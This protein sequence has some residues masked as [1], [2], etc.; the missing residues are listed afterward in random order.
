MPP[1]VRNTRMLAAAALLVALAGCVVGPDFRP[2][3][4]P[5]TSV[6][7][8]GLLSDVT[9]SA[10][11]PGG[12]AQKFVPGNDIPA[13]WWSLF[14][15]PELDQVIR[16]ALAN[17]PNLA[18]AQATLRVSLENYRALTGSVLYPSVDAS[19]SATH[20]KISGASNGQS[21]SHFSPFTLYNASVNVSYNLDLFGGVRRELEALQA[22]VDSQR[23]QLH[24]AYL[25]ITANIVTAAVHEALVRAQIRTTQEILS[26]QEKQLEVVR[27][28]FQLGAVSR[29]DVLAQQAQVAQTRATL[30][31]LEQELFRTRHLLAVLAGL[32]PSEADRLPQFELSSLHLPQELP[33]SLP[34][35]LVRR[36]PDIRASESL[37][38]AASAQV[39]VATAN[40][41]PRIRLTATFGSEANTG[42]D[43]FS[44]GTGV[45]SIGAGIFQPIF[46]GGALRSQKRAAVAAYEQASA[47]YRATVLQAFQNVA[48]VLRALETDARTLAAQAESEAASVEALDVA[49]K[50][51]D[52]GSVSF[53]TLL[54]AQRQAQQAQIGLVQAQAVRYADSA[55]L[56]QAL[57]GGWW[58]DPGPARSE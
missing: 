15:S 58:N 10:Q 20:D 21:A 51:F 17:N 25:T 30:P 57:G 45:W 48:D 16:L 49:R 3:E 40:L 12:E 27:R 5:P 4:A 7:T 22:Q 43:L 1:L 14:R 32:L 23:F 39:G 56:F 34:S 47:L 19:L 9:T 35:D 38:H 37:L 26:L 46:Q 36:R 2:P 53:L 13:A 54:N 8:S 11:V 24:G 29:P 52:L 50:Q 42:G 6:Y 18:A 28:Q 41:Y 33:V 44:S 31:P 55:A